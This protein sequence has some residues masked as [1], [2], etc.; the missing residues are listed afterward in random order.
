MLVLS[1][2]VNE[3]TQIY[4]APSDKPQTITVMI[5]EIVHGNKVKLGFTADPC[6]KILRQEVV[7]KISREKV[8]NDANA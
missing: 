4:V 6:V 3:K 8:G 7:A 5:T 2:R 1:H